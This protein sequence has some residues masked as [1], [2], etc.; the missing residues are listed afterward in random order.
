MNDDRFI[1]WVLNGEKS[2]EWEIWLSDNP[3]TASHIQEARKLISNL[4]F[5][6]DKLPKN[7]KQELWNRIDNS[8]QAKEVVLPNRR[9]W[10]YAIA[11]VASI[12][13]LA[14][15]FIN[16]SNQTSYATG[17][18][19][20]ESISLPAKSHIE[21]EASSSITYE[22]QN[23]DQERIVNL[24]G[25]ANINV[26]KGVPFIVKTNQGQVQVLG[27]QFDVFGDKESFIV[28]VQEG[29][30]QVN[31]GRHDPL[32]TADMSFFRNPTDIDQRFIEIW[33][34]KDMKF[35]FEKQHLSDVIS[36]LGFVSEKPIVTNSINTNQLYTGSFDSA[37]SL[38]DILKQ[39]FWPLQIQYQIKEDIITLN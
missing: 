17:I 16:R 15:F 29:K 4:K 33:K 36:A 7:K 26:S 12:A 21:L 6:E 1:D 14:L 8:T 30:V 13:L 5:R 11:S 19:E 38:N 9:K 25:Q 31:S 2:K 35:V 27:T 10:L 28:R 22:K 39:V 3:E 20:S 34:S 23:W 37:T 24:T 32:L 18:A